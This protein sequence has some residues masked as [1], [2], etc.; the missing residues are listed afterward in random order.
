MG[1]G[2][3]WAKSLPAA[4]F[5]SVADGAAGAA[6]A[7]SADEV[8]FDAAST[9]LASPEGWDAATMLST[10]VGRLFPIGSIAAASL[11]V[12]ASVPVSVVAL[13]DELEAAV[14]DGARVDELEV[15]VCDDVPWLALS[16]FSVELAVARASAA[17]SGGALANRG[18]ASTGAVSVSAG[19]LVVSRP[20]VLVGAGDRTSVV[21]GLVTI[22]FAGG[23]MTG[24]LRGCV[25]IGNAGSSA[26]TGGLDASSATGSSGAG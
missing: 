8:A 4:K 6:C 1:V 13:L 2:F 10:A 19:E 11:A 5:A 16:S 25:L 23:A 24:A 12:E 26:A 18:S 21:G 17:R 7:V 3:G 14:C 20:P 22:V 15:A 9:V